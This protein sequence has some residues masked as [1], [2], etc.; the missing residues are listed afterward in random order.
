MSEPF[1]SEIRIFSFNFPPAGW[2]FC[3]G[4]TLPISQ[5]QAL[6]SLTGTYYGGNGINTFNLPNL[7]GSVPL[8]MGGSFLLGNTGG[9]QNH[10][11]TV[12]ELPS[13]AHTMNAANSAATTASPSH[14]ALAQT[15]PS[16]G[17]AY[18]AS[19]PATTLAPQA[20][21]SVGGGQPHNNLQPYLVLNFCIALVGIFPPRN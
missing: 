4:Q 14:A 5:N 18:A 15:A 2:A 20:I 19:G 21:G 13:H 8:H 7:Q 1:L 3:N 11:V 6:F 17:A 12:Y 9:E 16:V 10:T